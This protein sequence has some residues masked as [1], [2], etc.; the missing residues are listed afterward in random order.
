[1]PDEADAISLEQGEDA[2]GPSLLV[3]LDEADAVINLV[4]MVSVR[5][6]DKEFVW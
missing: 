1:M 3:T 2:L 5:S 6:P 4:T